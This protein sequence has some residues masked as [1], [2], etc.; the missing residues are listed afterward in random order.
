[1]CGEVVRGQG[2]FSAPT[3]VSSPWDHFFPF[4][5]LLPRGRTLRDLPFTST[6]SITICTFFC[7]FLI[8]KEGSILVWRHRN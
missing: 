2:A 3:V 1:M 5:P 4:R 6:I 8:V 7:T